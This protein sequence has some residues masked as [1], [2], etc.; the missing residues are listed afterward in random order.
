MLQRFN[1]STFKVLLFGYSVY[2]KPFF[3]KRKITTQI[4]PF[5]RKKINPAIP[6]LFKYNFNFDIL[7]EFL[8]SDIIQRDTKSKCNKEILKPLSFFLNS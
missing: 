7:F 6:S 4:N 3:T 2:E 1:P 5:T 8:K